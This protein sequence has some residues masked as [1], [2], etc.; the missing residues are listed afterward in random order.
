[1]MLDWV[2]GENRSEFKMIKRLCDGRGES[3]IRR[4]PQIYDASFVF[5]FMLHFGTVII[6][7]YASDRTKSHW[8]LA[9]LPSSKASCLVI[10][11]PSRKDVPTTSGHRSHIRI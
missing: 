6:L 10:N 8:P 9:R 2:F 5:F 3:Y 1:M 11:E 4:K 7:R